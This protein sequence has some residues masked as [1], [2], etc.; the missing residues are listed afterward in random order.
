M[1]ERARAV[2]FL[3][4]LVAPAVQAQ[5]VGEWHQRAQ[6]ME[7]RH[8]E[9]AAAADRADSVS[10]G[11]RDTIRIGSLRV[12]AP[13]TVVPVARQAAAMAWAAIDSLYGDAGDDLKRWTLIIW[14]PGQGPVPQLQA[15]QLLVDVNVNW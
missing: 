14:E 6:Q 12:A 3:V 15:P 10:R 4:T 1:F 2:T 13:R 5:T 9:A 7:A 11:S 8:R